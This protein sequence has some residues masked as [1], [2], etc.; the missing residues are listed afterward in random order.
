MDV[1]LTGELEHYVRSKVSSGGFQDASAVVRAAL[2]DMKEHDEERDQQMA[3][4]RAAVE[5]GWNEAQAGQL[6]SDDDAKSTMARFK[7]EWKKSRT[8]PA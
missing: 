5:Q 2:C 6:V 1:S 8:V 4:L 7:E 3:C